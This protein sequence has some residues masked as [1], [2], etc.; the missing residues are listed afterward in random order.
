MAAALLGSRARAEPGT[1]R[2]SGVAGADEQMVDVPA[3][4]TTRARLLN[5]GHARKADV[6]DAASVAAVAVYHSRLRQVRRGPRRRSAV[7]LRPSR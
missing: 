6:L 7:A 3:Q 4:L 1:W 2:D 5:S